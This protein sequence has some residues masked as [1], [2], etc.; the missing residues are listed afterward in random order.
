MQRLQ[1]IATAQLTPKM[2]VQWLPQTL[3][4]DSSFA[5]DENRHL[6]R[7]SGILSDV[8]HTSSL[9]FCEGVSG[10]LNAMAGR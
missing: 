8:T 1:K 7:K 9:P 5:V 3:G 10:K 4:D 6:V 2:E